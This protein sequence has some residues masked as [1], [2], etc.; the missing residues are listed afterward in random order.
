M[1]TS[2]LRERV[3][4]VRRRIREAAERGR[5]S[6]AEVRLVA[7]T[8]GH[9]VAT[10]RVAVEAGLTDLGENRVE[11]LEAKVSALGEWGGRWHMIGRLQRR[12]A[13]RAR[14][15]AHL[16]HSVDSVALAERLERTAPEGVEPLPILV[17]VNTA[18]EEAKAGFAPEAFLREFPEILAMETL[19]VRGLMT[20]AP[21]TGEEGILRGSFRRL[22]ELHEEARARYDGYRG[23]ELSMGMSNDYELAVEEGSTMVRLGTVLFGERGG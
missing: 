13:P 15:L 23:N 3:E 18:G 22:R 21:L 14:E 1:D 19:D 5:W 4:E 10:C 6:S 20:M 11:E 2:R 17:Q 7:V 8:K 16:V 9:S 12:K